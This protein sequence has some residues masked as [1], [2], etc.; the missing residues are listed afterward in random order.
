MVTQKPSK[1]DFLCPNVSPFLVFFIGVTTL[2]TA[3]KEGMQDI[4][5]QQYCIREKE[6]GLHF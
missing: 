2:D 3:S 4:D 5:N 6:K 1:Q